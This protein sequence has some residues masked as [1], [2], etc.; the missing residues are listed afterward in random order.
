LHVKQTLGDFIR[1]ADLVLLGL[2]TASTLF[3]I[4]IIASATRHTGSDKFV[5]VQSAGMLL[6]I[7]YSDKS[8]KE[9]GVNDAR[10]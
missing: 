4:V 2:C 9:A 3:G 5:I 8:L 1:Q 10:S 7:R 6:G